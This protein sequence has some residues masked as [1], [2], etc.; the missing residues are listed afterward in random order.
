[1]Y[2]VKVVGLA[3][4]SSDNTGVTPVSAVQIE[5]D[6]WVLRMLMVSRKVLVQTLCGIT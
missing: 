1:M 5:V 3:A 2:I 4:W 6:P